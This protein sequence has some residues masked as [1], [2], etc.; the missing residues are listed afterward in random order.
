MHVRVRSSS[1]Q[2]RAEGMATERCRRVGRRA[3]HVRGFVGASSSLKAAA[4]PVP[5]PLPLP[6][7][8][9]ECRPAG[10]AS[11]T[12]PLRRTK[13]L[14]SRSAAAATATW[15]SLGRCAA[16]RA[17]PAG[18][19]LAPPGR[20]SRQRDVPVWQ[21][22]A[23]RCHTPLP[24]PCC[25]RPLPSQRYYVSTLA[26]DQIMAEAPPGGWRCA[27]YVTLCCAELC[28][29]CMQN[30]APV[31]SV[32]MVQACSSGPRSCRCWAC[33]LPPALA[34]LRSAPLCC[35]QAHRRYSN[36]AQCWTAHRTAHGTACV[37]RLCCR[38]VGGQLQQHG[39]PRALGGGGQQ[40]ELGGQPVWSQVS[41]ASCVWWSGA[42]CWAVG[43]CLAVVAGSAPVGL[44]HDP[45]G[46]GAAIPSTAPDSFLVPSSA[47][48]TQ[49]LPLRLQ[50]DPL[51]RPGC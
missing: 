42:S 10:C 19:Q 20:A 32:A 11:T 25:G 2:T 50:H 49:A 17:R 12:R 22:A 8:P 36:T 39:L 1:C 33:R 45:L 21:R 47:T 13:V 31:C 40:Q 35:P 5:P 43:L 51:Q 30:W 46:L 18:L 37:A 4:S 38:H 24:P 48:S 3:P 6:W 27:C 15:S 9:P 16:H 28:A 14:R 23:A 44:Q 41:R 29:A 34:P 7:L 26:F